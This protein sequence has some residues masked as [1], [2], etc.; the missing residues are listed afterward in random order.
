MPGRPRTNV[1]V[2]KAKGTYRKDRH[3][4]RTADRP[5]PCGNPVP[6]SF[7]D[8]SAKKLFRKLSAELLENGIFTNLDTDF[9]G[10]YCGLFVKLA[11][12][13]E[14]GEEVGASLVGQLRGMSNDLGLTPASRERLTI[15][16]PV[17]KTPNPFEGF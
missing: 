4:K 5:D 8:R 16:K 9:L 14:A 6:P 3:G 1:A 15:K 11:A 17:S 13:I 12:K 10:L 2:L 7:L